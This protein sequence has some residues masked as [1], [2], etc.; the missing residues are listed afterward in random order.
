[1]AL[2]RTQ[3]E[4]AYKNY[5]KY[6]DQ[7]V[8]IPDEWDENNGQSRIDDED[9]IRRYEYEANIIYSVCKENNYSK[10]LEI[11]SGPGVL[12]QIIQNMDSSLTYDF[13][14]KHAAKKV[15]DD[16][17]YK[18]RFY[19]KDLMNSF[20]ISDLDTDYDIVVTNDFLE[21]IA[22]PS[23]VLY[24]VRNITKTKSSLF[25]SVPNWRMGHQFIYRGLFDYDNYIYFSQIHGFEPSAVFP[26]PLKCPAYP[27]LSSEE[28]M[29]EELL[30]SWNWYF[31]CNK[32][33]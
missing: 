28:T 32:I 13:I 33:E 22:N 3:E 25:V 20:D 23:D 30:T 26:S 4:H 2:V 19:V 31:S 1:M 7:H 10:I 8:T 24:K 9:W 6:R 12:G 16:R 29:P 11:G 21:H 5:G 27:R 14:D 15:F 17:K 18:G